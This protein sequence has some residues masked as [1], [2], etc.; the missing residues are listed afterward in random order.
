MPLLDSETVERR[1][2]RKAELRVN[3]GADGP[4]ITGYASVFDTWADIGGMFKERVKRGAFAKSI[5]ESDVRALWNH[6]ERFVLGRNRAGTL[7]MKED[8]QG[9]FVEIDPVDAT[10]SRD[11]MASMRRG[12]VNQ[13]SFGFTVNE[14][15]ADYQR[16]ERTLL[17]VTLFDVSVVTYPAYPTTTAQVRSMFSASGPPEKHSDDEKW[18]GLDRIVAK[19]K[20]G[21]ALEDDEI[22]TL[23]NLTPILSGPPEKHSET[24]PGPPEK[25]SGA[26]K[27][28]KSLA[29]TLLE[30]ENYYL[31]PKKGE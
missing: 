26:E 16:G 3:P 25:H 23:H 19:I 4:T 1:Y 29:E 12:D 5:K 15:Q 11:L 9:L 31:L 14:Q 17:D 24:E 6:D 27:V 21:I 8:E 22:R 7:R 10:W 30:R 28:R 2:P 13:M 20:S 18:A